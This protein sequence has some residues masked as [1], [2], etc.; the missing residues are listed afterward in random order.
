MEEAMRAQSA[1]IGAM[2]MLALVSLF[3]CA[4]SADNRAR[5]A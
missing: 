3:G 1:A 5:P 2:A 4:E